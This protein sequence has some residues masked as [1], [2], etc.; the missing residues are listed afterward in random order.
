M[1]SS[2]ILYGKFDMADQ[3]HVIK[4]INGQSVTLILRRDKRLKKT[5]RWAWKED[6]SI[7]VRVPYRFPKWQ[8]PGLLDQ[9]SNQINKELKRVQRRTDADLQARADLINKKYFQGRIDWRAIR[10]VGNMELRLGSCTTGG[11]TDGHI[12]I[13]D[14]IKDWPDWVIDYVI[15]HELVHRLHPNH[16]RAFWNT[17]TEGYPK[18]ER[19]RGFI[20]GLGFAEGKPY[21]ENA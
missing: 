13:S 15:A 5:S 11:S 2:T 18:T 1:M 12:R 8:V 19:A 10:W 16:S 17:L 9:I 14:K 7:F 20:Q 3:K 6:G 21:D 4:G